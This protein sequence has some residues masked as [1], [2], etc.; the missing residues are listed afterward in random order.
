MNFKAEVIK[1]A[2]TGP[3]YKIRFVFEDEGVVVKSGYAEILK[4]SPKPVITY[5]A[6]VDGCAGLC[7][8]QKVE[9]ELLGIVLNSLPAVSD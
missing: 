6:D 2:I 1:E 8:A 7:D 4:H 5:D 3:Y 9:I